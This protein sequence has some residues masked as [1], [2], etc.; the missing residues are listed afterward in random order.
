MAKGA[1][2]PDIHIQTSSNNR[3][4]EYWHHH[5]AEEGEEGAPRRPSPVP[6]LNQSLS[7]ICHKKYHMGSSK[8]D[9]IYYAAAKAMA[10]EFDQQASHRFM[11]MTTVTA[12][13]VTNVLKLRTG[14]LYTNKLA[15]RYGHSPTNKCPLCHQPDGGY[16]LASGCPSLLGLTTA[17]HNAAG[18]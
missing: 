18:H 10:Q 15:F 7:K 11:T 9:T 8:T 17:R 14:N 5:P 6:D 12:R 4:N 13:E 2:A 16:H 1:E 3:D